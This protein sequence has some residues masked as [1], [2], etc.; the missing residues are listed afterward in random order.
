MRLT[1]ALGQAMWVD[2][3]AVQSVALPNG[4]AFKF[5]MWANWEPHSYGHMSLRVE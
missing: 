4:T 1:L 5:S 2:D 3:L